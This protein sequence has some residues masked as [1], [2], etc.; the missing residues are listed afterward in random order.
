[1]AAIC[2][3][4]KYG[5]GV[6]LNLVG[7]PMDGKFEIV[8]STEVSFQSLLATGLSSINEKYADNRKSKVIVTDKAELI[9]EEPRMLQLDGE[10]IQ[11][12]KNITVE[13]LPGAVNLI[14]NRSNTNIIN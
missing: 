5:T 10:V 6:P 3:A 9:F 4:R 12:Y 1:M 8:L 11:K 13:I 2:N 7:N 14:T